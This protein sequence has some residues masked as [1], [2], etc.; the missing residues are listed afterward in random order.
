MNSAPSQRRRFSNF[1]VIFPAF[2]WLCFFLLIPLLIVLTYSFATKGLYGGVVYH[3]HFGNYLRSSE[4]IYLNILWNSIVLA[5]TTAFSCLCIG[6]PMAYVMATA[7]KS[8]RSLLMMLVILPFWTN[9]VVRAYAIKL[10][11]SE[12]GPLNSLFIAMQL[13]TAPIVLTNSPFAVWIGMVTNYLPFMVLPL[14]VSLEKFDFTLLEAARDLGARPVQAMGR[15]MA[16]LVRPGL[17][18]GF[19]FVFTPALGEF[20]IPDLFGG[21]KIMLV[22]N[23][24]TDQFLKSRDWP[25]G[26]ALSMILLLSVLVSLVFY[27]RM[28]DEERKFSRGGS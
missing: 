10:L 22:G 6:F 25:F 15:V 20:V 24:V 14:Y 16:P 21:A 28:Q 17:V 19:I 26:A 11:L 27:L 5:L 2:G 7:K 4:F 8:T 12:N 18:T 23:L 3:F 9:F 13:T 1:A